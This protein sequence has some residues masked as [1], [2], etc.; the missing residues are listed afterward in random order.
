MTTE[1][2]PEYYVFNPHNKPIEELPVII[3][4]NNGGRAGWMHAQ[5]VYPDGRGGGS[6]FCS[7]EGYMRGDLGILNGYREDRHEAH[8]KIYPDGYRMDFVPS[9]KIDDH[10]ELQKRIKLAYELIEEEKNAHEDQ[11]AKVN[12][13]G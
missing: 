7:H 13:K 9:E 6:H 2:N 12:D 10:E 4:F 8:Q 3:G 1:I 5:L 11:D